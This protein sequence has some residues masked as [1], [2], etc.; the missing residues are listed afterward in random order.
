ME[1]IV[2]SC[3][4]QVSGAHIKT[5]AKCSNID[6]VCDSRSIS[7]KEPAIIAETFWFILP[8]SV[9]SKPLP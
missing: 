6:S 1:A 4:E 3:G 9:I 7:S 2:R 8:N 5:R